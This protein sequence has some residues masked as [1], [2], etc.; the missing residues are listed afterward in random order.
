MAV[1]LL[2]N[3]HLRTERSMGL[4]VVLRGRL[5]RSRRF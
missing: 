1:G 3:I 2:I 4:G 5:A